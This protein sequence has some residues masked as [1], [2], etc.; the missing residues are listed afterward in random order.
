[1]K[2]YWILLVIIILSALTYF[3]IQNDLLKN[4]PIN[5]K[6][7]ILKNLNLQKEPLQKIVSN[8]VSSDSSLTESKE[9]K[10]TDEQL[11]LWLQKEVKN[12][13]L[14]VT[15]PISAE[16][17]TKN[18]VNQLSQPQIKILMQK[19]LDNELAMNERIFANY[20]LTLYSGE[21]A[22]QN[23][24]ELINS[25]MPD[26]K[27]VQV[28]SEDEVKRAQDYALRYTQIDALA[29]N[30][31]NGD[32]VALT[33]L[34]QIVNNGTDGKIQNYAKRKLKEISKQ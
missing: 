14:P 27:N 19:V 5:L 25:K 16:Q 3:F 26:Y 6:N 34:T 30:A 33:L 1:M 22:N 4:E 24:Y 21:N 12:I 18:L 11:N 8:S 32:H 9:N 20:S 13:E 29:M 10:I 7:T 17:K 15:D 23:L 2:K 31:E 28:H